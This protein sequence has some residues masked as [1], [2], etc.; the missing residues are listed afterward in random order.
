LEFTLREIED[1]NNQRKLLTKQ[2]SEDA[3]Q[4]ID[5]QNNLIFYI[6]KEISH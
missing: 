1:L 2:F 4:K 6:D 3:M 5:L